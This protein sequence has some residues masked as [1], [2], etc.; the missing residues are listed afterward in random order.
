MGII[1][2]Q[3]IKGIIFAYTGVVLGFVTVGLLWPKFLSPEQIGLLSL[4]V[5]I[6]TLLVQ[7][8]SLG[9]INAINKYF[10]LFRDKHKNH[11][12][13]VFLMLVVYLNRL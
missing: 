5:A 10:P 1:R 7:V 9:F 11:N 6:S 13:F 8:G 3:S 12:G 2:K 4:I